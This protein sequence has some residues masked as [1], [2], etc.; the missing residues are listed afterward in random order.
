MT[1]PR[2]DLESAGLG[3]VLSFAGRF[4]ARFGHEPGWVAVCGYDAAL[5]AIEAVRAAASGAKMAEPSTMRA[6][7]L[8][9]RAV[10]S[11]PWPPYAFVP[12][13]RR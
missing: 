4:K 12:E 7:A 1:P 3:N 5:V 10:V 9:Y 8:Q 13:L 2:A 6:A 11:G